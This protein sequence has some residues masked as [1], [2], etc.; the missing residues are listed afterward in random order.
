MDTY[1]GLGVVLKNDESLA[2]EL[3]NIMDLLENHAQEIVVTYPKD[4][5]LNDWQHEA[6]EGRLYDVIDYLTYRTS[7]ADMMLDLGGRV[8]EARLSLT[9]ESD[10][11]VMKLEITDKGMF[12]DRTLEDLEAVTSIL[13]DFIEA[14]DRS[15]T[16]SY[17]FCDNEAEFL[18]TKERLLEVGYNPYA[19][20]KMHD[21]TTAYAA[22]YVDGF[23]E[24]PTQKV[25]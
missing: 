14:I 24:R 16:Y 8:V 7:Y 22:W 17:I 13:T 25:S 18:Y 21:R 4:G 20:L 19:I 3:E 9:N 23:T 6:I 10:V 1:I 12:K 2:N 15:V 11:A 5:D